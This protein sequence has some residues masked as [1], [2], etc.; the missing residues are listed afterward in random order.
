MKLEVKKRCYSHI[1]KMG[2]FFDGKRVWGSVIFFSHIHSHAEVMGAREEV[3]D[4]S[5]INHLIQHKLLHS[6]NSY[7][8]DMSV[9][10]YLYK[11]LHF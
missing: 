4:E 2:V 10:L 9:H 3:W 1:L 8:V 6:L 7:L 5:K 11:N